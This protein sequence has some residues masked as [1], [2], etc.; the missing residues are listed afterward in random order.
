VACEDTLT[1]VKTLIVAGSVGGVAV[2]SLVAVGVVA[3]AWAR[4]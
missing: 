4:G 3:S 2:I 1:E